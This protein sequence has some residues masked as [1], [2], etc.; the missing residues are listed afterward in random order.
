MRPPQVRA[1]TFISC[2]CCIYCMEFV[3]YWTLLCIANSSVP[4]QPCIQFLFV[5]SRFCLWLPSD[6][7]SRRTPLPLA[8][9]SYCKACS[10]LPPPS[11]NPCWAHDKTSRGTNP[12][13]V[14]LLNNSI[15]QCSNLIYF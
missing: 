6:S 14:L 4:R 12:L 13:E 15:F 11:Y 10:G 3:Q 9:S 2:N 5:S 8:N 7:A 1:I